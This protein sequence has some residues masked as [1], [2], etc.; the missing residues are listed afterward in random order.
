MTVVIHLMTCRHGGRSFHTTAYV[1]SGGFMDAIH[2]HLLLNHVPVIGAVI[3]VA[4]LAAAWL[5]RSDELGKAALVLFVALAAISAGVFVTGE[6]AEELIEQLPGFSETLTERH[7]EIAEVA[8]IV[9]VAVGVFSAAGLVAFR[10]RPLSRWVMPVALILALGAAGLMGYTANLGG[11]I[12][13][14]E[15]RPTT[16]AIPDRASDDDDAR[17]R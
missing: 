7:E 12:R 2:L 15:I 8:L 16:V 14:T 13:H 1:S 10:T 3:G 4:L 17:R 5:R 9:M 11:M 6:P